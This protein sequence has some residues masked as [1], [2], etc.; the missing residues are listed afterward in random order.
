MNVESDSQMNVLTSSNSTVQP[1]PHHSHHH[2]QHQHQHHF[3]ALHFDDVE[4]ERE[5][6]IASI[7][8]DSSE[9][10]IV[11]IANDEQT[12]KPPR[13][14]AISQFG[15]QVPQPNSSSRH[16]LNMVTSSTSN[17]ST[18]PPPTPYRP[19]RRR[20]S[21]DSTSEQHAL[22]FHGLSS[23]HKKHKRKPRRASCGGVVS[24]TQHS[25]PLPLAA[26]FEEGSRHESLM[27]DGD[28]DGDDCDDDDGG[29]DGDGFDNM[30]ASHRAATD[31]HLSA[32][33]LSQSHQPVT[34]TKSFL[35][36]RSRIAGTPI[37]RK[38]HFDHLPCRHGWLER[39]FE[40]EA[41]LGSGSFATAYRVRAASHPHNTSFSSS[42]SSTLSAYDAHSFSSPIRSTTT[43]MTT[44]T[45]AA[46][47]TV[48]SPDGKNE[49]AAVGLFAIKK[50]KKPFVSDGSRRE[51]DREIRVM[52]RIG[53][54][55]TIV[56]FYDAWEEYNYLY[57]QLELCEYGSLRQLMDYHLVEQH[58]K[59]PEEWIWCV[60]VDMLQA[61]EHIHKRGIE[62]R[63]LAPKNILL[64]SQGIFKLT[65]FGIACHVDD[66]T[67][68]S[69]GT[70]KYLAP[71][72]FSEASEKVHFKSDIFSLGLILYELAANICRLPSTGRDYLALRHGKLPLLHAASR[73]PE[74]VQLIC[75]MMEPNPQSRP[76]ATKL[77]HRVMS[78]SR[79]P[80]MRSK[81]TFDL[82]EIT[83]PT[84][85]LHNVMGSDEAHFQQQ[86]AASLSDF[87]FDHDSGLGHRSFNIDD[88]SL[89]SSGARDL[90]P[91]DLSMELDQSSIVDSMMS[92]DEFANF[93]SSTS[94]LTDDPDFADLLPSVDT[95]RQNDANDKSSTPHKS[96][97][98]NHMN[99]D[100][101]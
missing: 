89:D 28:D 71:E 91:V 7:Q 93:A 12:H 26:A 60:G 66:S 92:E 75:D 94:R 42:T 99:L 53:H 33:L 78:C 11:H 9:P 88:V 4:N 14:S 17:R 55:D 6:H 97:R 39:H 48:S 2:P 38:T 50:N 19:I 43:T 79:V 35:C 70:A 95:P 31:T 23:A 64:T 49:L 86:L 62:H 51:A 100:Q 29:D 44:T 47:A 98:H 54:C 83:F 8:M 77:L 5:S 82:P 41:E 46:A 22:S 65:D 81:Q 57:A 34:P 37:E 40:V 16:S 68:V 25:L 36:R 21:K 74:L 1:Q 73:S 87:D 10:F 52:K 3:G 13:R 90:L 67:D 58:C 61:L 85:T 15:L 45:A 101:S 96:P 30:S 24:S 56:Q 69:E 18:Q 32:L 59:V 27:D 76:A 20:D 84:A 72:I 63:D 80:A